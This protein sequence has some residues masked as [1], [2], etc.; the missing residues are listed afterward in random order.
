MVGHFNTC[1]RLDWRTVILLRLILTMWVSGRRRKQFADAWFTCRLLLIPSSSVS[2]LSSVDQLSG[3]LVVSPPLQC[4]SNLCV[5]NVSLRS[6]MLIKLSSGFVGVVLQGLLDGR[7]L[8]LPKQEVLLDPSSYIA[9]AQ[10]WFL[11]S[12]FLA[13]RNIYAGLQRT[14]PSLG[15]SRTTFPLQDWRRQLLD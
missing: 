11:M 4:R 12:F 14:S 5:R 15:W 7:W 9:A 1:L 3:W 8:H 10:S 13:K 2:T 6:G